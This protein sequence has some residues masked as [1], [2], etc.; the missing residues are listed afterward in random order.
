V[1]PGSFQKYSGIVGIGSVITNSP[2]SPTTGRPSSSHAAAATPSIG[3]CSSP[4]VT[5]SSGELPMKP[6]A[7]SVPPDS[8]PSS[9]SRFTASYTQWNA[10]AGSGEPVEPI[11]RSADRSWVS[12]GRM[13]AFSQVVRYPALVPRKVRPVRAASANCASADG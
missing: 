9:T 3:R 6:V 2:S 4:A 12:P 7:T 11:V 1:S 8:E 13:P 5:G 10:D